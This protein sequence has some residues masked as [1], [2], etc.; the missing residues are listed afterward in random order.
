LANIFVAGFI[1]S[2]A[3]NPLEAE[4]AGA[5]RLTLRVGGQALELDEPGL[6]A[7]AGRRVA[8]GVRPEALRLAGATDPATVQ[9]EVIDVEDLGA[10]VI[11]HLQIDAPPVVTEASPVS[12]PST[13]DAHER[14]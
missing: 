3:M 7:H 11:A 8:V 14:R 10:E 9:A 13:G 5:G 4:L 2:P 12:A 1:G 6:S